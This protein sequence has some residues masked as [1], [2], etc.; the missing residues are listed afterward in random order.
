M[1]HIR[2]LEKYLRDRRLLHAG[3]L[4]VLEGGTLGLDAVSFFRQR[5]QE[6]DGD[7][8]PLLLGPSR[9]ALSFLRIYFY[10]FLDLSLI[11]LSPGVL[12]QQLFWLA[13]SYHYYSLFFLL[14]LL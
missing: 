8:S 5:A 1:P 9:L 14:L 2:G 4:A 7:P 11:H 10:Y 6:L 12:Q 13:S 3:S